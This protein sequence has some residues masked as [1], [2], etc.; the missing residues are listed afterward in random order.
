MRGLSLTVGEMETTA[1]QL[2]QRHL[3][4]ARQ[5]M[6]P[7]VRAEG[8]GGESRLRI[9]GRFDAA[10]LQDINQSIEA[11]LAEHPTRV[12]LDLEQVSLM[13]SSG[14]GAIV[15]LWKRMKAYGGVVVVV[16]ARDQPLAVLQVLKLDAVFCK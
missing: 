5:T 12:T 3:G 6:G 7:L 15:S 9:R 1:P 14:V 13:D 4:S 10:T 11:V 8:D 2:V 16:G